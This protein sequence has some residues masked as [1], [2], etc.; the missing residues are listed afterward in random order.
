MESE[1]LKLWDIATNIYPT[2]RL[3]IEYSPICDW[4]IHI[5]EGVGEQRN[6]S[7]YN[8]NSCSRKRLFAR[9]YVWLDEYLVSN[10]GGY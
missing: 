9:A 5:A 8:D 4:N 1:F 3:T 2:L 6:N 10:N 7:L